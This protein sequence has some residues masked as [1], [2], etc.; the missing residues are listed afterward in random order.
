MMCEPHLFVTTVVNDPITDL[1]TWCLRDHQHDPET[2]EEFGD[3][4]NDKE[5]YEALKVISPYNI[6]PHPE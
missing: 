2:L 3:Y 1:M 6:R 4:F 5:F